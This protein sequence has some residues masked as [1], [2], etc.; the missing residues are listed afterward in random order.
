MGT[1]IS[2]SRTSADFTLDEKT[3]WLADAYG[4]AAR[5]LVVSTMIDLNKSADDVI[6]LLTKAADSTWQTAIA[7]HL[8]DLRS[9]AQR[10]R[11]Q[12]ARH[13]EHQDRSRQIAS[14]E[15]AVN[16]ISMLLEAHEA[17][18]RVVL[19]NVRAAAVPEPERAANLAATVA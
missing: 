3:Q 8:A 9:K 15:D 17:K 18:R 13:Q 6:D 10:D 1:V 5:E 7:A 14:L 4:A 19:V 11:E 12:R 16:N 2:T